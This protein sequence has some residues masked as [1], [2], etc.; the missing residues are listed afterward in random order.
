MGWNQNPNFADNAALC[1]LVFEVFPQVTQIIFGGAD[2]LLRMPVTQGNDQGSLT[3]GLA[4]RTSRGR[5]LIYV[6][7]GILEMEPCAE[8]E[9]LS[10]HG[11]VRDQ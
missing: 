5:R 2:K 10:K 3:I 11:P 1:N 9:L 4:N 6:R 8:L 7:A